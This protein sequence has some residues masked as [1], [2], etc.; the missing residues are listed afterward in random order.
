MLRTGGRWV[1]MRREDDGFVRRLTAAVTVWGLAASVVAADGILPWKGK[2]DRPDPIDS[3][4]VA[5][6]GGPA[7]EGVRWGNP[8]TGGA[9]RALFIAPRFTLRD[10][11]ELAYRLDM[12]YEV[13]ALWDTTHVGRPESFPRA[14]PG[15]GHDETIL[16]LRE[17]LAKRFDVIVAANFDFAILPDEDIHAIAENV[18]SGTGLVLAHHRR[19]LPAAFSSL[20]D[21]L[22]PTDDAAVITEAVG[23]RL[24]PEWSS[25]LG[26]V[27]TAILGQGRV[28]ELDFPAPAPQTHCLVPPLSSPMAA[29]WEH[30]DTYYSLA[31]RAVRWA[32]RR[33]APVS[34]ARVESAGAKPPEPGEVPPEILEEMQALTRGLPGT[35]FFHSYRLTLSAPAERGYSVRTQARQAGRGR[36]PLR[37]RWPNSIRKGDTSF[38]F[39]VLGSSGEYFLDIW[40]MD[41]ERI[42]E[43][44]TEAIRIESWPAITDL[45]LT[46]SLLQ[47]QDSLGVSFT[48][49]ARPRPCIVLARATDL[50]GRIVAE[51]H[52]PVEPNTAFVRLGLTFSD[53]IADMLKI[54][55]FAEDRALPR[56]PEWDTQ[57][58]A[59]AYRYIPVR[60]A[61]PVRRV[62]LVADV[63]GSSEFS[64]RMS[65]SALRRAGVDAV[66]FPAGEHAAQAIA[67]SGLGLVPEL[68]TYAPER[69]AQTLRRVPCLSSPSFRQNEQDR[70]RNLARD[71]RAYPITAYS[72]GN[73]NCLSPEELNLC[74]HPDSIREFAHWTR[75]SYGSLAEFARSWGT[76]N[77]SWDDATP[78]EENDAI[79]QRRFPPWVDFRSFMDSVFADTHTT[80][81]QTVRTV[82]NRARVGFA[83]GN[84]SGAYGGYD[85][86]RLAGTLD[87]V[88]VPPDPVVVGKVRS[89]RSTSSFLGI[90]LAMDRE[91]A[92]PS[93]LRW[94]P[95]YALLQHMPCLWYPQ[96]LASGVSV[97]ASTLIGP[98]GAPIPQAPE[99]W[100]Q[101]RSTGDGIAGLLLR[102]ERKNSG[103]AIYA[104]RPSVFL[105]HVEQSFRCSTDEAESSC[106]EMLKALG[107]GYDFISPDQVQEG[108]LRNYSVLILPMA[109]ALSDV[110]LQ[111]IQSF[112]AGSGHVIADIIPG[113]YDEHGTPRIHAPLANL[114]GARLRGLSKASNKSS[115]LVELTMGSQRVSA[116][117]SDVIADAAVEP[118]GAALG[119]VARHAPLWLIH[120]SSGIG[121]LMN[122]PFNAREDFSALLGA[123]L[124]EAGAGRLAEVTSN[125][126]RFQGEVFGFRYGAAEITGLLADADA[127]DQK[128]KTKFSKSSWVY[129]LRDGT[130]LRRS[131]E[132]D[133]RLAPGDTA[134]Y[135]A[136]PYEVVECKVVVQP[137]GLVGTR[138]PFHIQ[139]NVKGDDAGDHV[140]HVKLVSLTNETASAAPY[141]AT[142]V[143]CPKGVGEG[144]IPLALNE[145]AGMYK[146]VVRDA[147]SGVSGESSLRI[148]DRPADSR[149]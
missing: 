18:R 147:L 132:V 135:A 49:E 7:P 23:A 11:A 114:F 88:F 16:R 35:A 82:D 120:R 119:G 109:R 116:E 3:A 46:K 40:L 75:K 85:W 95:W 72:L 47:P 51:T 22:T 26:F 105:N 140:A 145:S 52:Q 126:G 21:E 55:V 137:T 96:A 141:Y 79:A 92:S 42:A 1:G 128:L 118:A 62:G 70:L 107:Y 143:V 74:Q 27:Q 56:F 59:Y 63:P 130:P 134:L 61:S 24:T 121:V 86:A 90:N 138:L 6:E 38:D 28:V 73:G 103:I 12:K 100:N 53:L 99:L 91:P 60:I 81:R 33:D 149:P 30:L 64:A 76:S 144:Y 20:L 15:T 127:V 68:A 111:A 113:T 94:L 117:F 108:R 69:I 57:V 125:R 101:M 14:I 17:M 43:W 39:Y 48:M 32:G 25:G 102:A 45:R 104:S 124:Q 37:L 78:I 146:L 5:F 66:A 97:P 4:F 34:I 8:L 139:L 98:G 80:A 133:V 83:A 89:F 19:S 13:V 29:E 131:T 110:E 71:I 54:E 67:L 93:R 2:H 148:T 31:A 65:Y 50:Y 87:M 9:I 44:H 77:P 10:V 41:K 112:H 115:G 136:L 123:T 58:A 36:P 106:V 84:A 142:D 122:H 129:D